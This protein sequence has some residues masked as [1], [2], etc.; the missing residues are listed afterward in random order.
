MKIEILRNFF[1]LKR[2]S[3]QDLTVRI[4]ITVERWGCHLLKFLS[5]IT[6]SHIKTSCKVSLSPLI[7]TFKKKNGTTSCVVSIAFETWYHLIHTGL[8]MQ[9]SGWVQHW[10]SMMRCMCLWLFLSSL[11]YFSEYPIY[12]MAVLLA[13]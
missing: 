6:Y 7:P 1:P 4:Y 5:S 8:V 10:Q 13:K 12:C 2:Q 9:E 11:D 3:V